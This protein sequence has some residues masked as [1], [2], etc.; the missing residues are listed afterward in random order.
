M[1]LPKWVEY[2]ISCLRSEEHCDEVDLGRVAREITGK[3]M[4]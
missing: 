4:V 2:E 3:V 1:S